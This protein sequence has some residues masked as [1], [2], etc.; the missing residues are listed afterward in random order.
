MTDRSE[1]QASPGTMP[2]L[3]TAI[4]GFLMVLALLALQMRAGHDPAVRPSVAA[5]PQ[6]S[7]L[8]RRI[9]KTRVIITDAPKPSRGEPASV[10]PASAPVAIRAATVQA[11]PV[12]TPPPAPAPVTRTS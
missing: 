4:G 9:V 5:T 12:A 7:I 6:R 10:P 1:A 8:E 3:A 2:V 11:A